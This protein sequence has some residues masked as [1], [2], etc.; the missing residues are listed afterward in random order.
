MASQFDPSEFVDDDF[1]PVKK[2]ASGPET[3]ASPNPFTDSASGRPVSRED[4]ET[5]VTEMHQKL[6]ELKQAQQELE[7][8]R[9]SLEELRRRQIEFSKGR[10]EMLEH[11]TR[12]VGLLE[13]AEFAAR[14]DAEQMSRSLT[15]FREALGK[16]QAIQEQSWTQENL[17][18]ELTR[19]LTIIENARM[20]WNAARLKFPILSGEAGA[21]AGKSALPGGPVQQLLPQQSYAELCKLGLAITWPLALL[22]LAIFVVLLL[23]LN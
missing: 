10:E 8:E 21:D 7:R 9:S 23:R 15:E 3:T 13:D 17:N 11:L 12:G 1:P 14:R 18:I 6:A 22:A 2:P 19:A 4:V 16:I 20:E 5:R